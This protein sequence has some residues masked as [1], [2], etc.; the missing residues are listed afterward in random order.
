MKKLLPVAIIVFTAAC[1]STTEA[2]ELPFVDEENSGITSAS[3]AEDWV[4]EYASALD[5]YTEEGIEGDGA[6]I[7]QLEQAASYLA[8]DADSKPIEDVHTCFTDVFLDMKLFLGRDLEFESDWTIG[9][10]SQLD[11]M[12]WSVATSRTVFVSGLGDSVDSI[13]LIVG[14]NGIEPGGIGPGSE[15][16]DENDSCWDEDS[17]I[18]EPTSIEESPTVAPIEESDFIDFEDEFEFAEIETEEFQFDSPATTYASIP[19]P[20]ETV[21]EEISDTTFVEIPSFQDEL[22]E[23]S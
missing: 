6:R 18:E 20:A 8:R 15:D 9:T 12:S 16:L 17:A 11:S 23:P 21:E 4:I 22:V 14:P 19:A 10:A 13:D 3:E 2:R 5:A 1:S 7:S